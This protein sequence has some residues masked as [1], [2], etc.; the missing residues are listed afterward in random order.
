MT[1]VA[2]GPVDQL[3]ATLVGVSGAHPLGEQHVDR[4]AEE[5][6]ARIAEELLDLEVHPHDVAVGRGRDHRVGLLSNVEQTL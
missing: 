5:L 6:F 2:I 4:V 1:S 3:A